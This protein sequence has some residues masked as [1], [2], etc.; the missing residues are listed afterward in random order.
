MMFRRYFAT[1]RVVERPLAGRE[2]VPRR[3]WAMRTDDRRCDAERKLHQI[4]SVANFRPSPTNSAPIALVNQEEMA[5][6]WR[7]A[8]V[9]RAARNT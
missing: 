4:F 6:L 2:R 5:W 1:P 7:S 8:L 9:I 3:I